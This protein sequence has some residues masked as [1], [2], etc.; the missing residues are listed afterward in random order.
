MKIK[1]YLAFLILII[2]SSCNNTE[3][4]RSIEN[5]QKFLWWFY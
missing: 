4:K 3:E 5:V 1:K 2:F